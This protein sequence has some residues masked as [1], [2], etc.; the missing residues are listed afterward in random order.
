LSPLS[1][2]GSYQVSVHRCLMT[3]TSEAGIFPVA[4]LAGFLIITA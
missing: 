3:I 2:T 4:T 1:K